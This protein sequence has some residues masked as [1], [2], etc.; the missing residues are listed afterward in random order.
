MK[1]VTV[2][3]VTLDPSKAEKL[4]EKL[5]IP[6]EAVTSKPISRARLEAIEKCRTPLILF[7]DDDVEP[8]ENLIEVMLRYM[9]EHGADVVEGV[10]R[11]RGLGMFFNEAL[12]RH[13]RAN[14]PRKLKK[15]ERGYTIVTLAKTELLR[16]WNPPDLVSYE[17]YHLSQYVL[18]RGGKWVKVP[19]PAVH[20]KS[21][22]KVAR[23]AIWGMRG[24]KQLENPNLIEK[25]VKIAN[26]AISP[27][28]YLAKGEI[29]LFIYFLWQKLF[30]IIGLL[31]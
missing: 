20:Y 19:V 2:Y 28:T 7:I 25:L 11:V 14:L 30:C 1:L 26:M 23:N 6:V 21:W 27:F 24:W 29:T 4:S 15:G 9:E 16:G 12:T 13:L 10:C 5:K 3:T 31:I 8:E 17:D 18:S 22:W